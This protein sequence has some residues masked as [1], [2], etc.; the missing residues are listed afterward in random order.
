M[1]TEYCL[2]LRSIADHSAQGFML[3]PHTKVDSHRERPHDPEL[4][5]S[6]KN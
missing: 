1:R 4:S 5:Q 3:R 2:S 6:G